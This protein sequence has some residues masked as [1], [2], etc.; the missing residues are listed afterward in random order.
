MT[1]MFTGIIAEVGTLREKFPIGPAMRM[2]I[3]APGIAASLSL[4][5]SVACNGVCLTAEEI[6]ADG[7][8]AT[9]VPE[10]L[11]R[12]TLGATRRGD[13]INLESALK[14][15]SPM[16]GH[17]VQGHVDGMGTVSA[18]RDLPAGAGKELTIRIP[19]T[20]T[21]Y[22]VEKGSICLHGVS[23]TIAS[24]EADAIRI[25]LV[26]H[27]LSH[28]NLGAMKPGDA[29]NFEVDVIG[30][31]VEKLLGFLPK[32]GLAAGLAVSAAAGLDAGSLGKWGYGV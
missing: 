32:G 6:F 24:L 31:Y 17:I 13:A 22:C 16:G 10:T 14:A 20:Q 21:R 26:P 3:S 30:K 12:T 19:Q 9:A 7:F 23:L 5:D 11:Q 29:L 2:H 18:W 1:I 28:T 4:G 8:S 15:G 25:A 27:T